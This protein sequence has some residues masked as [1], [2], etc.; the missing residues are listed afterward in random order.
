MGNNPYYAPGIN[1]YV[2]LQ[3]NRREL[4]SLP[5]RHDGAVVAALSGTVSLIDGNGDAII[6]SETITPNA[7]IA[8]YQIEAAQ[9]PNTLELGDQYLL[10]WSLV[11]TGE[12]DPY[13]FDQPVSIALRKLRPVISDF[14]LKRRYSDLDRITPPNKTSYQDYIDEAWITLIQRIRDLGNFEYLIMTPQSLREVHMHLTLSRIWAD[15]DSS[16]FGEGRYFDLSNKHK[17][18][19]EIEFARLK[20]EYDTTHQVK[21]PEDGKMSGASPMIYTSPPIGYGRY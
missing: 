1:L 8:E 2:V 21:R 6:D 7:G 15:M 11:L 16:G 4:V 19:Y 18:E 9:L 5:V 14:D 20:F 13:E 17:N 12:A 10:Q 3:R